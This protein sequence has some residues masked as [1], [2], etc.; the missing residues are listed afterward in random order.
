MSEELILEKLDDLK[1]D[2]AELDKHTS[3]NKL[4]YTN[5]NAELQEH[6]RDEKFRSSRN[7]AIVSL[8]FTALACYVAFK[9]LH[10]NKLE[11]A[12]TAIVKEIGSN[13][14]PIKHKR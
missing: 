13:D 3:L 11:Q 10:E 8:M 4:A 14:H 7:I 5:L 9:G 12:P 6:K 2:I 1:D